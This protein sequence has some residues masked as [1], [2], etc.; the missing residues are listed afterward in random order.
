MLEWVIKAAQKSATYL[1][2]GPRNIEVSVALLVPENDKLIDI[3]KNRRDVDIVTG[4]EHDVLDRYS[5]VESDY[6]VRITSDCPLIP[7]KI[8]SALISR[9]VQYDLDYISNVEPETRTHPDGWDCE[10]LS[11]RMLTWLCNNAE[12]L[13]DLEHVTTLIRRVRPK[14][15][16][17]A[18]VS[19]DL[20]DHQ[21]KLSVDT[22][23]DLDFVRAYQNLHSDKI[24]KIRSKNFGDR[25]YII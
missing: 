9:A 10:V 5:K 21:L 22:Q 11:Q 2:R 24:N 8:I 15:Y 13:E 14:D 18:N 4:A 23:E 6:V 16:T 20:M 7:P 17:I 19:G 12:T 25:Y 3:Y 1:N